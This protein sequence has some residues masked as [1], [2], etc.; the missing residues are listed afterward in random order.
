MGDVFKNSDVFQ[1]SFSAL[2]GVFT[3]QPRVGW[4]GGNMHAGAKNLNDLQLFY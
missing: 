1:I 2:L 3:K 4:L